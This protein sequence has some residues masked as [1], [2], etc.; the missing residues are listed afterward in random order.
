MRLGSLAVSA[1]VGGLVLAAC[2]SS[3]SSTAGSGIASDT[4]SSATAAAVTYT[5]AKGALTASGSTALQPL[6]QKA[7][8]EYQAKCAGATVTVS[9]GG[10][11]TGLGNVATGTSDIGDSDVPVAN[12]KSVDPTTV[13][14]HQVA[15]VVFG[16]VVNPRAGV[17][18]LTAQQVQDLFSGKVTNWK[19]VGGADLP[20]TLIE[21]KA[22]S[23]T[24]LTFDRTVMKTVKETETPA[25]TEDSTS[26]VVQEVTQS[27]G[28]VSY[29]NVASRGTLVAVSLDGAPPNADSVRSGSYPFYA[30]EHMYTKGA[31]SDIARDFINFILSADFQAEVRTLGFIPVATT[32][33]QSAVDG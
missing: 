10:S 31:G 25:K 8:A 18:K 19:E 15:I 20:V 1:A 7:A 14:D 21:R 11:S 33:R 6:V 16:V 5:C 22:G 32:D 27:D 30:H 4:T 3:S 26:L 12:A 13:T 24:R 28:G 29:I 17:S 23:G 2:G 9:G